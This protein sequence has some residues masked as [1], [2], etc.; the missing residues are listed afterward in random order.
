[1]IILDLYVRNANG[2]DISILIFP[3]MVFVHLT[4]NINNE[5]GVLYLTTSTERIE[6]FGMKF[7]GVFLLILL[8]YRMFSLK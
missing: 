2:L 6:Y 5:S 3:P 7:R 1:M 8:L 4:S